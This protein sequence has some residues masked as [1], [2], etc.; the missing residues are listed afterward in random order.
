MSESHEEPAT[1]AS[2]RA[3]QEPLEG[4][5]E[6]PVAEQIRRYRAIHDELAQRLA[7]EAE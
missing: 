6:L 5:H 3:T 2:V 1:P 4:I 7:A